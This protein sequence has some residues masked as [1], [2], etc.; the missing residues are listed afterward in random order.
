MWI[1][2]IFHPIHFPKEVI[3]LS[4]VLYYHVYIQMSN[5]FWI[6]LT[7]YVFYWLLSLCRGGL[8]LKIRP[9]STLFPLAGIPTNSP[10]SNPIKTPYLSHFSPPHTSSHTPSKILPY[11]LLSFHTLYQISLSFSNLQLSNSSIF[12]LLIDMMKYMW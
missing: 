12:H 5:V 8:K 2:K 9:I 7:K 3:P 4:L 10:L 1:N 6:F 11:H